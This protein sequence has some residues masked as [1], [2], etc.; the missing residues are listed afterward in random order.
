MIENRIH[1]IWRFRI[2]LRT[3]FVEFGIWGHQQLYSLNLKIW[4]LIENCICLIW[5]LGRLRT[6]FTQ[7]RNLGANWE[8]YSLNL[9]I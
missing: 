8:L 4:N 3:V 7:S 9:D 5:A 1:S 2:W 6:V